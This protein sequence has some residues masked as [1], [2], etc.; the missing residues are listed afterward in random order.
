MDK[1]LLRWRLGLLLS[2]ALMIVNP[3]QAKIPGSDLDPRLSAQTQTRWLARLQQE[4]LMPLQAACHSFA[5]RPSTTQ[6]KRGNIVLLHGFTACPQQFEDQAPLWAAAGYQVF[7][8]V[9]PGHGRPPQRQGDRWQDDLSDMPDEAHY[10]RY[11]TFA[12]EIGQLL[13]SEPGLNLIS[14]LSLG[15]SIAV[16]AFA[17]APTVFDRALIV[18]PFMDVPFPQNLALFP[19]NAV[20]PDFVRSW[21]P[22]CELERAAGRNGYCQYTISQ[23]RA[24]QHLGQDS[25]NSLRAEYR[26]VQWVGVAL[27]K[28]VSNLAMIRTAKQMPQTHLCFY[29]SQANHSLVSPYD[30]IDKERFWIKALTR[31]SLAFLQNGTAFRVQG[32]SEEAGFPACLLD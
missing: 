24:S 21:D 12:K 32:E 18:T 14:G 19:A 27:D 2:S 7:V 6:P 31:D 4:Q 10:Q 13:A 11:Q 22:S 5:L 26:P 25:Q 16:S 15:G 28:A 3:A 8:P 1:S 9:L 30:G 23:V 29:P 20:L 17:Q